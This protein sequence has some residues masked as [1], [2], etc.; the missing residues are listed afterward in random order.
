MKNTNKNLEALKTKIEQLNKTHQ[1]EILK[2]FIDS[3]IKVNENKSGIF[4]NLS[5]LENSIVDKLQKYMEYIDDQ[6]L[7][8]NNL[9]SQKEDFKNTY[10]NVKGNKD[11]MTLT[12]SYGSHI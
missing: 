5:F 12:N 3:D 8:L 6:E 11:N 9:E 1:L 7:N 4:I 10:F 2:I